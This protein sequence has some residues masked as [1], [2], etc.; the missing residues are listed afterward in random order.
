MDHE[1][2]KIGQP[3]MHT[4]YNLTLELTL[5]PSMPCQK[6]KVVQTT[7]VMYLYSLVCI[8]YAK[9]SSIVLTHLM[10]TRYQIVHI[11]HKTSPMYMCHNSIVH[12]I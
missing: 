12:M 2:V 3:Y 1:L 5:V 10:P 9:T 4:Q 6:C 8:R 11:W 7:A